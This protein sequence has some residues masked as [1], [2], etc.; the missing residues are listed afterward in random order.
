M[1][2]DIDLDNTM[3]NNINNTIALIIIDPDQ[4]PIEIQDGIFEITRNYPYKNL[5]TA[6]A[7][8]DSDYSS[9]WTVR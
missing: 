5:T 3:S 2:D 1:T 6:D 7:M 4:L 8:G 9:I